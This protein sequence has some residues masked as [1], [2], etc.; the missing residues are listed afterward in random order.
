M[1]YEEKIAKLQSVLSG[2]GR[3]VIALSGGVDSTFLL[4]MGKRV[5]G[6]KVAAITACAPNFAPD[7]LQDSEALCAREEIPHIKVNLG[8][9]I[10][11]SFSHNP[12]DRCYI[13]KKAIFSRV[14]AQA[15][16]NFPGAVI[17]DGTNMDDMQDYRPGHKALA[18][19]SIVSPLK[20][21]CLTKA[22]I[23]RG[24]K[25]LGEPVWQKP[26]F[27]C[28]ASRIPYGQ[29]ITPEKLAAVYRAESALRKLGFKQ[30]RIRHHGS[31]ARIEVEPQ[32]RTAFFD[33]SFMDETVRLVKEAGFL[34]VTLDLAGYRMGSLNQEIEDKR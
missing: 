29:T 10:L 7:E 16:I 27:A 4:L 32:D 3:M 17:A 30:V 21:A 11:S 34:Y 19:L 22:E 2:Y 23:R 13:C 9:E 33:L 15:E 26:A 12:P 18:E 24:L 14:I 5:L 20:E 28:L 31:L 6:D 8:D 25:E 1:K